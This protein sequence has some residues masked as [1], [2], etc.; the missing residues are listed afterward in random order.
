MIVQIMTSHQKK[1]PGQWPEVQVRHPAEVGEA[2]AYHLFELGATAL[3]Q[4]E[5]AGAENIVIS[6]AGFAPDAEVAGLSRDLDRY[7]T[8]IADIFS[9]TPPPAAQ[10]A[11]RRDRRLDRKMEGRPDPHGNRFPP[12]RSHRPG[13]I[14]PPGRGRP[15]YSWT[16]A[17]HSEP[18]AMPLPISACK[19]WPVCSAPAGRPAS[20]FWTWA[21]A[22][23]S[24]PWL[25]PPWGRMMSWLSISTL[26]SC[27]WPAK[28]CS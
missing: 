1:P 8:E 7:L 25:V 28:T 9:I 16:R 10:W 17:R 11:N 5:E 14:S 4:D 22:A 15:L 19:Y 13:V 6:R 18:A 3:I 12:W 24:W 21:R 20:G 26:S 23:A 27:P 2:L